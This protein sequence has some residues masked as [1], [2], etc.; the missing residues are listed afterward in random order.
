[1]LFRHSRVNCSPNIFI[2]VSN[3]RMEALYDNCNCFMFSIKWAKDPF[4]GFPKMR[5]HKFRVFWNV[6]LSLNL[7]KRAVKCVYDAENPMPYIW[8][9]VRDKN[10][11]AYAFGGIYNF[12]ESW[13]ASADKLLWPYCILKVFQSSIPYRQSSAPPRKKFEKFTSL[14]LTVYALNI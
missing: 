3:N 2:I 9:D 12:G 14:V 11:E 8:V 1:M 5:M 6:S 4:V 7:P 13:K 10:G